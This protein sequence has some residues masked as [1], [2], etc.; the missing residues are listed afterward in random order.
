MSHHNNGAWLMLREPPPDEWIIHAIPALD[1][2]V[3]KL[4][5]QC[6]CKPMYSKDAEGNGAGYIHR[7]ADGREL[8]HEWGY[9]A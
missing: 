7:P 9:R 2:R 8:G 4:S 1:E 6:W 3:H 5:N